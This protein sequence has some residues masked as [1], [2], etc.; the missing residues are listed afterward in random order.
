MERMGPT[1]EQR[2]VVD[3]FFA[4][5]RK[6]DFDALLA[7][8]DPDVVL[9]SDAGERRRAASSIRRGAEEIARSALAFALPSAVL[10]PALINGAA[11]VVVLT[12]GRPF[13]VMAFTVTHG[14]SPSR[15][16]NASRTS[17]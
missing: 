4:A 15:T 5:P 1:Y 3:A 2:R 8:L 16:P 7:V 12:N 10:R 11:G 14:G 6:G 9:R 17:I 13:A